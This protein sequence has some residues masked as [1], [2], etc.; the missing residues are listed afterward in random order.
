MPLK[1]FFKKKKLSPD[2][3]R[4]KQIKK[5]ES[6]KL[7]YQQKKQRIKEYLDKSGFD[8]DIKKLSKTFFNISACLNVIFSG[9]IIYIYY[10]PNEGFSWSQILKS[11]LLLWTLGSGFLIAVFWIAFYV[12]IDL[13]IYK[14]KIEVEQVLPDFLQLTAANINAGMTIDRALW[15]AVRPRFGVLANEIEIV[16]KDTMGGADLKIALEKFAK[17]YDSLILKRSI[18]MLNEGVEAGGQ[19]GELLNRIALDIQEQRTMIQEMA[20]N[21]TT[22]TI[23]IAFATIVAAPILFSLSGVFIE[24]LAKLGTVLGNSTKA[25]AGAG[26]ALSFSGA[27]VTISDFTIFAVVYLMMTSIFS[28]MMIGTIKKGNIKASLKLVPI[29]IAIALTIYIV[30]KIVAGKLIG[31]FF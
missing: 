12:I 28:A 11:L 13:R 2:E 14:R 24:V 23:F 1:N 17:K 22:Y 6:K 31:L 27:G 29:F 19:I 3:S 5:A 8:I 15:F 18:S 4:E 26:F 21:I 7:K 30:G 20:A 25:A 9:W 16:A 10:F